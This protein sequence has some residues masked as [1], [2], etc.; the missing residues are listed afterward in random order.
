MQL[1]HTGMTMRLDEILEAL[2]GVG[3]RLW[4]LDQTSGGTTGGGDDWHAVVYDPLHPIDSRCEATGE[5][6]LTAMVEALRLA[7]VDVSQE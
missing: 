3:L 1:E 2:P 7:G 5:T 4:M 6:P